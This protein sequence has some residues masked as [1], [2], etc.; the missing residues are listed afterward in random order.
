MALLNEDTSSRNERGALQFPD[1]RLYLISRFI[2]TLGGRILA[3]AIGWEL[4]ERTR[5]PLV[6]G[7]VGLVQVIPALLFSLPAGQI[8]DRYNRKTLVLLTS[9]L[10]IIAAVSL[11]LLSATQGPLVLIYACLFL[12]GTASALS[13]PAA[14][15]LMGQI[16]PAA[17]YEN[18]ASWGSSI[19]QLASV[20][21][22]PLGGFIIAATK[23]ATVSYVIDACTLTVSLVMILLISSPQTVFVKHEP[24]LQAVIQGLRF[25]GSARILLAAVTLDMFAVLLGGAVALLP[26]YASDILKVGAD[27]LGVLEAA[28]SIG[29][30]IMA[31]TLANRPPF[32]RAGRTLLVAVIGFGIATIIFGLSTSFP[33]SLLMLALLGAFDNIS[34]VIRSTLLLTRTPDE[35]RGRISSV[36]HMFIAMSNEFGSFES[37][38]AAR[39]LGPVGAVVSGGIGTI[40]VVIAIAWIW[41]ELRNLGR[42]SEAT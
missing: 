13:G 14:S 2:A 18:A 19:W 36:N 40:L 17:Y 38:V 23:G 32:Q 12:I 34:V 10:N 35:M 9:L 33:L 41:P 1:Y 39:L 4:Y 26:V 42:M 15:A 27:G 16:V 31:L 21:G 3:V 24:P 5:D 37:G 28:P 6:L 25:I 29:A 22:P 8:A 30:V 20:I 7:F 11:A